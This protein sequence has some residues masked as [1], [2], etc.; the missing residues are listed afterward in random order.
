MTATE[1]N[2]GEANDSAIVARR[3]IFVQSRFEWYLANWLGLMRGR[4]SSLSRAG[5][6]T[7]FR[8]APRQE[9]SIEIHR[10]ETQR[11]RANWQTRTDPLQRNAPKQLETS[12]FISYFRGRSP[13]VGELGKYTA[14]VRRS[15]A[16][17]KLLSRSKLL[18]F[19][20]AFAQ[21]T[22]GSSYCVWE[23]NKMRA[24]EWNVCLAKAERSSILTS[25]QLF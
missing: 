11:D 22:I 5:A 7:I 21:I 3:L 16:C 9:K 13:F 19:K 15:S 20:Q 1:W 12:S 17:S 14:I 10:N 2:R 23:R 24:I 6:A 18:V 4:C 25:S 8:P